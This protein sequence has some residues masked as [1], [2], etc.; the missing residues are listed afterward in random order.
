MKLLTRL[1]VALTLLAG[2]PMALAQTEINELT[3]ARLPLDGSEVVALDQG[4]CN[5]CTR[6]ATLSQIKTFIGTAVG[7]GISDLIDE[8]V[9]YVN[10]GVCAGSENF[11]FDG[12]RTVTLNDT[13]AAPPSVIGGGRLVIE[14]T[15]GG[16]P[17]AD[18]G[19]KVV[20]NG[21]TSGTFGGEPSTG[22]SASSGTPS[23][24]AALNDA[25]IAS[26]ALVYAFNGINYQGPLGAVARIDVWND[27][28]DGT[29]S[30]T[31]MG[32]GICLATTGRGNTNLHLDA[33]CVDDDRGV[34]V[35]GNSFTGVPEGYG[36][37]NDAGL[38]H[39]NLPFR[40][41]TVTNTDSTAVTEKYTNNG[42]TGTNAGKIAKLVSG[43][44]LTLGT[45]DTTDGIG[46]CVALSGYTCGTTG[47]AAIAYAGQVS[48]FFDGS[49][50]SGDWVIVST[51]VA[52]DCADGGSG[53]PPNVEVLGT[54]VIGGTG[55]GLYT[56][57]LNPVGIAGIVSSKRG[58]GG[59]ACG[60]GFTP[61]TNRVQDWTAS[62][63][64]HPATITETA[65]TAT[66]DW[67]AGN[68]QIFVLS[69]A[70]CP[71][72]IANPTNVVAGTTGV[73][74]IEQSATGNDLVN[75]WGGFFIFLN[76]SPPVLSTAANAKDYFA[77][78][79]DTSSRI[80]VLPFSGGSVFTA[81][82]IVNFNTATPPTVAA[83]TG[84]LTNGA[85]SSNA[86]MAVSA[87]AGASY[88]R[89]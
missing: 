15:Q 67:S 54:V 41:D 53:T 20:I 17:A 61:C 47:S 62:Q 16:T 4:L 78:F 48:C 85:N 23:A 44:V 26:P 66:P 40:L 58:G 56:V 42:I 84:F 63:S 68:N 72:T 29:F 31:D 36:T 45:S 75:T 46:I 22:F 8:E 55:A 86:G 11:I 38:Y 37:V 60:T 89:A 35:G 27:T 82:Q 74:T 83:D 39:K 10:G 87:F 5:F 19:P 18:A 59:G 34:I 51:S 73:L 7:C 79:V 71:C 88:F 21:F 69:H 81:E 1:L 57:D 25:L 14:G 49:T 12:T 52:G 2:A 50:T 43:Q 76:G 33:F 24:P 28:A 6:K 3:Q 64:G 77:F 30:G 70:D 13:G 32:T 65:G 9:L 80:I